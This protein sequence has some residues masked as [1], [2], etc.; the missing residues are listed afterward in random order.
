MKLRLIS[1][2]LFGKTVTL[3][4]AQDGQT[5]GPLT[6]MNWAGGDMPNGGPIQ[7]TV[8]RSTLHC[9]PDSVRFGVDLS[10]A[11]FNTPK[12]AYGEVYDARLHDL[13]FIWDTGDIGLWQAADHILPE[14]KDKASAKGPWIAHCYTTPGEYTVSLMVIEQPSGKVAM[15]QTTITVADPNNIYTGN[16]TVCINPAGDTNFSGAP[17]GSAHETLSGTHTIVNDELWWAQYQN[18]DPRRYLFKAGGVYTQEIGFD[19]TGSTRSSPGPHPMFATYG[20]GKVD[21]IPPTN[22]VNQGRIFTITGAYDGV[23]N[24]RVNDFR[25]QNIRID[26]TFDSTTEVSNDVSATSKASAL[27]RTNKYLDI[28]VQGCECRNIK[29]SAYAFYFDGSVPAGHAWENTTHP[30]HAHVDECSVDTYGGQYSGLFTG[31]NDRLPDSSLAVT[32]CRF[33]QASDAISGGTQHR[34]WLRENGHHK[35]YMTCCDGYGKETENSGWKLLTT[36]TREIGHIANIHGIASEGNFVPLHLGQNILHQGIKRTIATNT[37]IDGAVLIGDYSTNYLC[38]SFVSGVTLRNVLGIIPDSPRFHNTSFALS[39]FSMN[40]EESASPQVTYTSRKLVSGI[41]FYLAANN[42]MPSIQSLNARC[43]IYNCTFLMKRK[44]DEN[45]G[46]SSPF[47]DA[48]PAF[49][50]VIAENNLLD[51]FWSDNGNN[52]HPFSPLATDILWPTRVTDWKGYQTLTKFTE[53]A[54]PPDTI[55]SGRPTLESLAL[56]AAENGLTAYFDI[57]GKIRPTYPSI[58]AWEAEE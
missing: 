55:T 3:R 51:G 53:F 50:N 52:P 14:W 28:V 19:Y 38:Q 24:A 16:Q 46:L 37:I 1:E 2:A 54:S 45:G 7:I 27:V 4:L 8:S 23:L 41:H 10:A 42:D 13:I 11:T 5:A 47:I 36:L 15:A 39:N 21:L 22:A 34:S 25:I 12:P 30:A 20:N 31:K 17:I 18:G 29:N 26:G 9:A 48:D 56:G 6:F 58:G 33:I 35:L 49:T 43:A 32:G 40:D 44:S 57:E